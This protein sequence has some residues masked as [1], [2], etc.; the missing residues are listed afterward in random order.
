MP[1]DPAPKLSAAKSLGF[2]PGPLRE[3]IEAL[4]ADLLKVDPSAKISDILRDGFSAFW[5]QIEAYTRARQQC[6]CNPEQ[7]AALTLMCAH[8][9]TMG[10]T[11]D[12]IERTLGDLLA[13]RA[14]AP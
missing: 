2:R 1:T 9:Q 12:D 13:A 3:K 8:A 11:A 6:T 14:L 7:L 10:L 5:P 4:H